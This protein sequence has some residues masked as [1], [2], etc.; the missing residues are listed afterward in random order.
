MTML[1][2]CCSRGKPALWFSK[3]AVGAASVRPQLRQFQ[4]RSA[5]R[6]PLHCVE[7][8]RT[9]GRRRQLDQIRACHR[10][11]RG[12]TAPADSPGSPRRGGARRPQ[13]RGAVAQAGRAAGR[14][15]PQVAVTTVRTPQARPAPDL[16]Q[17][18]FTATGPNQVWVADITYIP[19]GS[20]TLYLAVVLGLSLRRQHGQTTS[21]WI[22][23]S[24]I[25]EHI[26]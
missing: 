22:A 3:G 14:Q 23:I 20:G 17:R 8:D 16:V 4:R 2:A 9:S 1:R 19:T 24:E 12:T 25:T 5:S 6:C 26:N 7:L 21:F 10:Q 18:A 11:S 15:S 13:A